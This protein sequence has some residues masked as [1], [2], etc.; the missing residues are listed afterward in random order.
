MIY[1]S[2]LTSPI[3]RLAIIGDEEKIF[4]IKPA[5][6]VRTN[7]HSAAT[8]QMKQQLEEWFAGKRK[9]FTVPLSYTGTPFQQDI[10]KTLATKVPYGTTISY[11]QLATLANHPT[12]YR[13]VGQALNHNPLLIAVPCH[14]VIE[15]DGALGGFKLGT[16]IKK[17]LL[18]VEHPLTAEKKEKLKGWL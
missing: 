5:D 3:G 10:F 6:T 14:R 17:K 8:E 4:Y 16:P 9:E 13:A 11:G 12:A 7:Q 1:T 15:K 18:A 2:Y